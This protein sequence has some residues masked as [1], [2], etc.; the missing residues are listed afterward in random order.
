MVIGI[1][2][3]SDPFMLR[4]PQ[5]ERKIVDA[6][7]GIPVH[8]EPLDT[9]AVRPEPFGYAQDMLCRRIRLVHSGQA[10]RRVNEGFSAE[11]ISKWEKLGSTASLCLLAED[12]DD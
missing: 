11:S 2:L 8:P 5:H 7:N 9:P 4:G 12:L 6:T 3:R 1:Q 10:S